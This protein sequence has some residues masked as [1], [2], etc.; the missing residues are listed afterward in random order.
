MI[1]IIMSALTVMT[2]CSG[3]PDPSNPDDAYEMFRDALFDGDGQQMWIRADD[4]THDYFEDR[5]RRLVQMDELIDR[6]LPQ[7]DHQLA[8]TQ[9]GAELLDEVESGQELFVQLIEPGD[10]ADSDAVRLGSELSELQMAE[11]GES[12]VAVT[13]GGQEF[14]LALQEDQWHV[15]LVDSGDF[16]DETFQWLIQNEDALEQTVQ[17]LI[18]EERQVREQ[19]ISELMDPDEQ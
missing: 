8:R 16:L 1:C 15:N 5:Y 14:A 4:Q 7:T 9:S 17:D 12:A 13:R 19:I 3:E 10:F 18:E 11:D 6:Y 2:G